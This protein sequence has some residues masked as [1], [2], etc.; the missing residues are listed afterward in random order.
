[1]SGEVIDKNE[2]MPLGKKFEAKVPSGEKPEGNMESSGKKH[3]EKGGESQGS[4]KS[5]KKDDKK[6]KRMWK[7]VYYDTDTSSSPFTSDAESTSSKRYERKLVNQNLFRYPHNPLL[8]YGSEAV[9]LTDLA[10][11]APR[12]TFK[13][14]IE[15]EATRL[16]KNQ[17]TRRGTS[18]CSYSIG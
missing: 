18:K 9:L 10:F 7:V 6:K 16:E 4:S 11:R 1:M 8:V 14:T 3:K 12:L 2:K 17:C 15:A 5:Q 13:S